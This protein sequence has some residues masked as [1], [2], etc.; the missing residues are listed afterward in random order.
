MRFE[1]VPL[2]S[3]NNTAYMDAYI[4][5]PIQ[6]LT[7]KAILVIAGGAYSTV[8]AGR[9][10]EPIAMAFLAHG[11]N[12]FVLNYTVDRV[13]TF[14]RQ[15][16]EASEAICYIRDH[17]Q[18]YGIDPEQVFAVGF[19]A[20]GHLCASLGALWKLDAVQHAIERPHGYNRPKGVMLIYPVIS[21]KFTNGGTFQ[22]LWA[23]D[24]LT[25]EQIAQSSIE[26]HI[27]KDSAPAFIVHTANDQV[28]N[29][30]NALV[31]ASAYSKAGV[32]FELHIFPDAPHG[33][34]LG[35]HITACGN[36]GWDRPN[37]AEWVR[38]AAVW[39]DKL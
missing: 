17:A 23:T 29:V 33:V 12:A 37:I 11:Y 6:G 21:G 25:A 32:P 20:G 39:A 24:K 1:R 2:C 8:C 15:L 14:P 36:P 28:V 26:N 4:A 19:S 13:H 27:D 16:I 30:N 5:D 9:E 35:N 7:R 18:E 38:L 22:N 10:G 34:A 31:A 3:D